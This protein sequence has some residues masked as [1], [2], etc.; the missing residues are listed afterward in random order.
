VGVALQEQRPQAAQVRHGERQRRAQAN[1]AAGV[2]V[3]AGDALLHLFDFAERAQGGFV[4]ALAQGRDVQAARGAVEQAHAQALFQLDQAAADK[5][6]GQPKV[7]GGGGE[8]AGF[9]DLAKQAHVFEG[10]HCRRSEERRVGK[11][12]R[13][14]GAPVQYKHK[15]T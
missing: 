2:G 10:V 6:L 5:L 9:H 15:C 8:T 13:T 14:W 7:F 4:V 3:L 11:R 12:W 1:G